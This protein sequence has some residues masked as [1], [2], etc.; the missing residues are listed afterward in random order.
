MRFSFV[1]SLLK[2]H[3][4]TSLSVTD[5]AFHELKWYAIIVISDTCD[6]CILRSNKTVA[7]VDLKR[8]LKKLGYALVRRKRRWNKLAIG[9]VYGNLSSCIMFECF[10][11]EILAGM[12]VSVYLGLYLFCTRRCKPRC[13]FICKHDAPVLATNKGTGVRISKIFDL[14]LLSEHAKFETWR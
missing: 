10:H 13:I 9:G 3:S 12:H 1:Y 5:D 4:C 11:E 8:N 14:E 7:N 6:R 2:I